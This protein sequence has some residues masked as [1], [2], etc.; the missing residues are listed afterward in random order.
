MGTI[1]SMGPAREAEVLERDLSGAHFGE[2]QVVGVRATRAQEEG[3]E[4][5]IYLDV[6]LSDP[7]KERGTW[8]L[9]DVLALRR[10]AAGIA[11][12]QEGGVMV[13]VRVAP[14]TDTTEEG[15]ESKEGK[16]FPQTLF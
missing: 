1:P 10:L 7:P 6:T 9:E 3:G 16:G 2:T 5:V 15:E 8:P 11:A 12:A 14:A 4:W 13:Y